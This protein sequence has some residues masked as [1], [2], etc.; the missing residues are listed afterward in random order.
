M[1]GN[2]ALEIW[3]EWSIAEVEVITS[4]EA[5]IPLNDRENEEPVPAQAAERHE[6]RAGAEVERFRRMSVE[7][8][9]ELTNSAQSTSTKKNTQWGLKIFEGMHNSYTVNVPTV[10]KTCISSQ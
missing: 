10:L 5:E 3:P 8:M 1:F 6:E 7:E 9:D 4:T 2:F